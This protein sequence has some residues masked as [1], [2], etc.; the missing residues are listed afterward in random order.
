MKY[1]QIVQLPEQPKL[2][3]FVEPNSS[4]VAFANNT[5]QLT[6]MSSEYTVAPTVYSGHDCTIRDL[7]S[8]HENYFASLDEK[9]ILKIWSLKDTEIQRRRRSRGTKD[10]NIQVGARQK[11][12]STSSCARKTNPGQ[13]LQTMDSN[14]RCFIVHHRNDSGEMEMFAATA[15]G[16]IL[17]CKWNDTKSIFEIRPSLSFDAHV[18]SIEK[19]ILIQGITEHQLMTINHNGVSDFF[20]LRDQ[21]RTMRTT[22][23]TFPTVAPIN[24]HTLPSDV[25][26]N[27][28]TVNGL[29]A[30]IAVVYFDRVYQITVS[31]VGQVLLNDMIEAYR[32]TNEQNFI[33][34]SSIT[35]DR[36]YLILGTRKG[37][38][39]FD[40]ML[41]REILR[42]SVSDNITCIDVCSLDD[43]TYRYILI[44]A[45]KKGGAVINVHG[46]QIEDR[47]V[48]WA[49][50]RNGSLLNGARGTINA[51]LIGGKAFDA[52]REDDGNYTLVAADEATFVHCISSVD[53]FNASVELRSA[54]STI[55]TVSIGMKKKYFGCESGAICEF[56]VEQ[57]LSQLDESVEYLKY[58]EQ[59]DLLIA[60]TKNRKKILAPRMEFGYEG[61]PVLAT[62]PY[63]DRFIILVNSDCSFDVSSEMPIVGF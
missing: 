26:R 39:V 43:E 16:R 41:K 29:H 2:I 1:R 50:N 34:C 35:G 62:F 24:V 56:S 22:K 17:L 23:I 18:E 13:L 19:L 42:S 48:A 25:V 52:I 12:P 31:T 28:T 57:P 51:W 9:G 27:P 33:T 30:V 61:E 5:I 47:V 60:S 15:R 44:S 3:R 6:D 49:T 59:F 40:P 8:F 53:S 54:N 4:L 10:A 63:R 46:I 55:T 38:I 32:I 7:Q 20:N 58:Y 14:I 45:T 37:I 21:S 11:F 36:R